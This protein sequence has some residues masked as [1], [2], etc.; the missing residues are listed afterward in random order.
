M[1]INNAPGQEKLNELGAQ[2]WEL[3]AVATTTAGFYRT[4]TYLKRRISN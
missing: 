1:V 4:C 2:G 3:I